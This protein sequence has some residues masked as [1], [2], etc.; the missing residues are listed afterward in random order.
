MSAV[1]GIPPASQAY[2]TALVELIAATGSTEFQLRYDDE[3]EPVA[4]IAVAKYPGVSAIPNSGGA[5]KALRRKHR[6][7]L[8]GALDPI[9]AVYRLA[10]LL[11]DGGQCTTCREPTVLLE[12]SDAPIGGLCGRRYNRAGGFVR[13]CDGG[14]AAERRQP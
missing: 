1:D 11:I 7:E 4:W 10:E 5:G 14:L 12:S 2:L 9:M 6:A 8:A 3:E 13:T